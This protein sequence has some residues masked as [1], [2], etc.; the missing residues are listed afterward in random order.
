MVTQ[1]FRWRMDAYYVYVYV[2][3]FYEMIRIATQIIVFTIP[4]MRSVSDK[5][6]LQTIND[7]WY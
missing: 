4:H 6:K 1:E 5:S 7:G 2:L 3:Q